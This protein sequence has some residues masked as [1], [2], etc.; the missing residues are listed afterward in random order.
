M[1]VTEL[2]LKLGN[3]YQIMISPTDEV[4]IIKINIRTKKDNN[5][6]SKDCYVPLKDVIYS[7]IDDL[8]AFIINDMIKEIEY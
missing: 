4:D 6:F 1:N 5:N 8:G 2:L 3:K 7:T